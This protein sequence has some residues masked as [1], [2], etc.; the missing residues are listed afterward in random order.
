MNNATDNK[1]KNCL[2]NMNK[3]L[4]NLFNNYTSNRDNINHTHKYIPEI[5]ENLDSELLPRLQI[6]LLGLKKLLIVASDF[7]NV[8]G[9]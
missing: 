9:F 6:R 4:Q 8:C 7:K 3:T 5:F 2:C 1:H